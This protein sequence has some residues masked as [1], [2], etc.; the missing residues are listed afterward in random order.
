[1]SDF[2][3]LFR[4]GAPSGSP[5]ELQQQMQKWTDWAKDLGAGGH[6]RGGGPLD[7]GGK[8]VK[9]SE[10]SVTD[11]AYAE[12]NALVGGYMLIEA[13]DLNKAVDLSK[14]CPIFLSGGFVEVRSVLGVNIQ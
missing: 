8:I 11:G 7:I 5:E 2:I 3:Y 6:L 13:E 12:S 10:K 9:G 1:M 14:E 4:G